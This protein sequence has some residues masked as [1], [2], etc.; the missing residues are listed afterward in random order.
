MDEIP[1]TEFEK[2]DEEFSKQFLELRKV[3]DDTILYSL[4][5]TK[6]ITQSDIYAFV[7][8]ISKNY[9]WHYDGFNLDTNFDGET[10]F[11]GYIHDEWR[12]ILIL[13]K[14]SIRFPEIY[15]QIL[16]SDGD[17]LGIE[18]A[19]HMPEFMDE[20]NEN[21]NDNRIWL[22]NGKLYV[23]EKP[24][25]ENADIC[26]ENYKFD[27]LESVYLHDDNLWRNEV[28]H[29]NPEKLGGKYV[30]T[31]KNSPEILMPALRMWLNRDKLEEKRVK[32]WLKSDKNYR[33]GEHEKVSI[34][35]NRCSLAQ[36]WTEMKRVN[37]KFKKD[38]QVEDILKNS[39]CLYLNSKVPKKRGYINFDVIEIQEKIEVHDNNKLLKFYENSVYD[40]QMPDFEFLTEDDLKEILEQPI[41][42][43][44]DKAWYDID[45][46]KLQKQ[47]EESMGGLSAEMID[48][49]GDILKM[50]ENV[51]DYISERKK[52]DEKVDVD[53]DSVRKHIM[54]ILTTE[55]YIYEDQDNAME[56]IVKNS[57]DNEDD[58]MDFDLGEDTVL[59]E[60]LLKSM[61]SEVGLEDGVSSTMVKALGMN[62]PDVTN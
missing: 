44:T 24:G 40:F 50:P 62:L 15:I 22:K 53:I 19:D 9:L 13:Y 32:K 57:V 6:N 47:I 61:G 28:I 4:R 58:D 38:L 18:A 46:E 36:V 8:E 34:E 12:I 52:V 43:E 41:T 31:L 2:E 48:E 21:E 7:F 11:S 23:G 17:V 16:D 27:R 33:T 26:L 39:L 25:F 30:F 20:E 1:K 14:I 60:N 3:H 35:I 37:E 56:A 5:N 54:R 55:D 59:V 10:N 49:F 29:L 51:K 42:E 45:S